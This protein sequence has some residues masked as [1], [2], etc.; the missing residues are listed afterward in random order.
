MYLL[1]KVVGGGA[2]FLWFHNGRPLFDGA[3]TYGGAGSIRIRTEGI[4]DNSAD[5][6]NNEWT[7]WISRLEVLRA[8]STD[9]GNYTCAPWRGKAA[10]VSVFISQG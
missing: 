2:P 7:E 9:A 4:D 6:I 5:G 3:K 10:S 8:D 1:L